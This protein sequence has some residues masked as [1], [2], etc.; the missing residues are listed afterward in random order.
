M[1]SRFLFVEQIDVA[2]KT[3]LL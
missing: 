3:V 2:D 1:N